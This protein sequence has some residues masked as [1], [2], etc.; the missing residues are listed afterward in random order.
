MNDKRPIV[1]FAKILLFPSETRIKLLEKFIKDNE[2]F[3][4]AYYKLS[5]EYLNLCLEFSHGQIKKMN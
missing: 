5:N 4:P 3:A 2:T 1:E